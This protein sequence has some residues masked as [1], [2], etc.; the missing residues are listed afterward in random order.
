MSDT[1]WLKRCDELAAQQPAL[2]FEL[3]TFARDGVPADISRSMIDYLSV[4]QFTGAMVSP[5]TAPVPMPEFQESVKRMM[6]FGQALETD[7]P[8]HFKRM[9]KGWFE[10]VERE[11]EPVVWAG[12]VMTL[13]NPGIVAH[14][15]F[16][17]IWVT[18]TGIADVYARRLQQASK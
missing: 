6:R 16:V 18:L 5:I 17:G 11:S 1:E 2:F 10:G 12:C 15:L 9:M 8:D 3:L 14:P 4:L 13:K 7:D